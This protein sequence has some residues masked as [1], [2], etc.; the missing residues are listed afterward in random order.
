MILILTENLQKIHSST[1][2]KGLCRIRLDQI[3]KLYDEVS[4]L[5]FLRVTR[6]RGK[7]D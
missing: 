7:D 4:L 5:R 2:M 1:Q 3:Y 6:L